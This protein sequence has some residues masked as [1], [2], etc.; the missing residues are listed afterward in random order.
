MVVFLRSFLLSKSGGVGFN[1]YTLGRSTEPHH[2]SVG[3]IEMLRGFRGVREGDDPFISVISKNKKGYIVYKDHNV[4]AMI[5]KNT[6]IFYLLFYL[7]KYNHTC[8]I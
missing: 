1:I 6:L 7:S 8:T 5:S 2:V 3:L 4:N